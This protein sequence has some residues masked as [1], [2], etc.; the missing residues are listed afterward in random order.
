MVG[1]KTNLLILIINVSRLK[2]T[3]KGRNDQKGQNSKTFQY[4]VRRDTI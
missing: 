1:L 2:P 3:I 4:A